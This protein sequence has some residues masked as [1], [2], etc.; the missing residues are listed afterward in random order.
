[1]PSFLQKA[2]GWLTEPYDPANDLAD[3]AKVHLSQV[4]DERYNPGSAAA[5]ANCGPTSVIM[6][7]RLVGAKVPGEER[8][9]RG[10]ALVSHVRAL[11][12]GGSRDVLTGTH[13]LHLQRVIELADCR[14]RII[15]DPREQLRAVAAGEPVIMAGN[16]TVPGCYT[17]RYDY[18]DV[19]RWNSGHW[20]V[21]SRWNVRDRNF[22][23]NDPQSVIG[24]L[25]VSAQEL[26]AFASKDGGFGIAVRRR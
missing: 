1:M 10:E 4:G 20:I 11:A 9:L 6:A 25:D 16:P 2:A 13:N 7:L 15:T 26:L 19:R 12:T 22:T 17:D 21:V 24:P 18:V 3:P 8:G 14:F 23:I 5:T